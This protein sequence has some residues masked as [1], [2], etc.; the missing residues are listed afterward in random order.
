MK[1][2]DSHQ[3]YSRHQHRSWPDKI[4]LEIDMSQ[5]V[6]VGDIY[7]LLY[8]IIILTNNFFVAN[9]FTAKIS[10]TRLVTPASQTWQQRQLLK[11]PTQIFEIYGTFPNISFYLLTCKIHACSYIKLLEAALNDS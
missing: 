1:H 9:S 10:V 4:D 11:F 3:F 5:F 7:T 2:K 8:H 6:D